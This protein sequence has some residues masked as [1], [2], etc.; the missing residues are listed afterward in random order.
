MT[1]M[2][3][4]Q[5]EA[6][7]QEYRENYARVWADESIPLGKRQVEADRLWREFDSQRRAIEE[8]QFQG[9]GVS[10]PVP[11]PVPASTGHRLIFPR[12]RRR[13]WK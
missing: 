8:G 3:D 6:L 9:G 7:R 2:E 5:I 12:K 1:M 11:G 13:P 4:P 10:S